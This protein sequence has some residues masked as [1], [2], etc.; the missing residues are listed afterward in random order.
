MSHEPIGDDDAAQEARVASA[1][2]EA[3]LV[4]A[5]VE[6]FVERHS[7]GETPDLAEFV[8]T[9][10]EAIRPRILAQCREFL[11]FDGLLGHQPWEP[12]D[13][14]GPD[15]TSRTFGDFEIT[16]ELGRGGMGVVYLARQRS[17]NRRVALKVMASGLTLSKRH[18]ERFRREAAATAQLRHPAIVPVHSLVEVDGTFAIAMDFIA[19]RNLADILDDLRL[20]NGSEP[21]SIEGTLGL[22]PEKGYVAECAMLVAQIASALS[23]AH[24]QGVMHRDLKPRNLMIDERRQSRLLDFGLS[25]SLGDGSLSMSGE[26]TGTVHYMSPEQTLAKRVAVDHRTD[27]FALGVILYELLTL[28]RPFDG[29]NMQ[30]IVYEICFKEPVSPQRLNPKVPR[31][32]VTICLKALEKDPNNR[33][34]SAAELEADLQRFLRWEPIQARPAGA[35]SRLS[36]WLRR[37]RTES[38]AAAAVVT[39]TASVL[40][41][42]W[43]GNALDNAEA[44]RLLH[45]AAQQDAAGDYRGAF[46]SAKRAL[47]R[48]DDPEIQSKLE[49]YRAH[50]EMAVTAEEKN[51]A[52]ARALSLES[53]R[54][55]PFNR[56][57]AVLLALA[58]FERREFSE[59]RSAVLDALGGGF[60]TVP[61]TW[62][63]SGRTLI[64]RWSNDGSKVLTA[65]MDDRGPQSASAVL[66]RADGSPLTTLE[67]H[68]HWIS[69]AAFQPGSDR[70]ATASVDGTVRLWDLANGMPPGIWQ[71]D[72]VVQH[73]AF[74]R[75]GKRALTHGY[76][77]EAGPF[78]AQVWDADTGTRLAS[79]K[80]HSRFVLAAAIAPSGE[81]VATYGDSDHVRLWHVDTDRELARLKG[82]RGRVTTIEF[83]PQS[84][85]VAIGDANG[86]LQ[87]FSV[88]DGKLLARAGHSREIT[89][90]Q[91][92]AAGQRL[93]T[94]SHDLS[95]RLWRLEPSAVG[96]GTQDPRL[97]LREI[98]QFVDHKDAVTSARFDA[99]EEFVVTGSADGVLRVF[100]PDSD[101]SA[102]GLTLMQYEL[103][104]GITGPVEF[105]PAG[106]TDRI[107]ALAGRQPVIWHCTSGSGI[108]T[109]RQPGK[110]P[111][112]SFDATG[113]RLATAG[114]DERLR[115]WNARDG[116][117]LWVSE[118]LDN[119]IE[120]LAIDQ[121]GDR[122]VA[123]TDGG[124][125]HVHRTADGKPL[126][127][128]PQQSSDVT[129]V[130]FAANGTRILSASK[131]G[132]AVVWN[133]NDQTAVVRIAR[134]RAIV[135]ADLN[136]DATIV[137][138]VE[139]REK[140]ARLWNVAD[141][142]DAG[143]LDT[144][145][146]VF[147]VAFRPDGAAVLTAAAD[148]IVRIHDLDGT[149][150]SRLHTGQPVKPVRL[151]VWSPDGQRVLTSSRNDGAR[152]RLWN[153]A[154]GTEVLRFDARTSTVECNAFG[155]HGRFA[156][157]SCHDGTTRIWPTDPVE[158][159]RRLN[160][161]P[162]DTAERTQFR[163]DRR[164]N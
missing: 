51:I 1:E 2:S 29:K 123:S 96:H 121:A 54:V 117:L 13:E 91:F 3:A 135:A 95:A 151:A 122:I 138:T 9:Y 159:A 46:E 67:G 147:A 75:S 127:A 4:Q 48:R 130:R 31:D 144:G 90:L 149:E 156:V 161:R 146:R 106:D 112:V 10:P 7:C 108:V 85:I 26:I 37:H 76:V 89:S 22:E 8:Q 44:D 88:P 134:D 55:L 45:Q 80:D 6:T 139:S 23:A 154:D 77:S 82:H 33:Y 86:S 97:M 69:D 132:N 152:A 35:F 65:A 83:G 60:R 115:L 114:D 68:S 136:H 27:V 5:A 126:F 20:A 19:G 47:A 99:N 78:H 113:T 116:S 66:W 129:V 71:H 73:V 164:K 62:P 103:G 155:P 38:I 160:L 93:L 137:A 24:A 84:D 14:D 148:G 57:Q 50:I 30:Q 34:A 49:T 162:L 143:T 110:V 111:S 157:T 102:A 118:P 128:L 41:Y 79:C 15:S 125:L 119:P 92:D 39:V 81:F 158:L 133:A 64:A 141:G 94:A 131:N 120:A 98:H 36:K 40:G 18:V 107:L 59:S 145:A 153:V 17:L 105:A 140:C 32:L 63:H 124:G 56:R 11:A 104:A 21:T 72:G 150:R 163:L 109:L 58:A 61:L 53:N 43:Y 12:P 100:D 74:D 16:E 87:L 70:V 142:S 101:G 52:E 42:S 28:K 25:K